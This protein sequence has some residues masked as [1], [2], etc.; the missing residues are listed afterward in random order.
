MLYLR[1]AESCSM[2]DSADLSC[3]IEFPGFVIFSVGAKEIEDPSLLAWFSIIFFP[4]A[5]GILS[6]GWVIIQTL[7]TGFT[8]A[9]NNHF[10]HFQFGSN[11]GMLQ[12]KKKKSKFFPKPL[13]YPSTVT[14]RWEW[15]K[16][17]HIWKGIDSIS[18][19]LLVI[20]Q[21]VQI[22]NVY[23]MK[24]RSSRK[25][26]FKVNSSLLDSSDTYW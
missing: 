10:S 3:P 16:K 12:R 4:P 8:F 20:S 13:N 14:S 19:L 21:H 2:A 6:K 1:L 11:S 25:D 22:L 7:L 18:S 5:N 9:L 24:V 26:V 15:K 17:Q 23:E